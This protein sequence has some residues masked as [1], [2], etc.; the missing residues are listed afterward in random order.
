MDYLKLYWIIKLI[1][2][3]SFVARIIEI[4]KRYRSFLKIMAVSVI[5]LII[6]RAFILQFNLGLPEQ[7]AIVWWFAGLTAFLY[8]GR[9]LIKSRKK[10]AI[11]A[12][13]ATSIMVSL[14]LAIFWILNFFNIYAAVS[15]VI[16]SWPA[17][18]S[19]IVLGILIP[20][21]WIVYYRDTPG[22]YREEIRKWLKSGRE[23]LGEKLILVIILASPIFCFG[24]AIVLFLFKSCLDSHLTTLIHRVNQLEMISLSGGVILL[25]II[26]LLAISIAVRAMILSGMSAKEIEEFEAKEAQG[27]PD[28]AGYPLDPYRNIL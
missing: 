18:V 14:I 26:I 22:S 19:L 27:F 3:W 1:S 13:L 7:Q 10:S 2:L 15:R 9:K 8:L 20:S 5:C 4:A 6:G 23:A 21:G 17:L 16:L 28:Q 24:S 11:F 25:L 12:L